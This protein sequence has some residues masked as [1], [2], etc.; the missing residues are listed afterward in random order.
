MKQWISLAAA[1]ATA[2][3][4]LAGCGGGDGNNDAGIRVIHAA[5][6][7]P[8]VNFLLNG[9]AVRFAL[10]YRQGTPLLLLTQ[11]SYDVAIEGLIPPENQTV[12]ELPGLS[13]SGDRD[14]TVVVTG[15]IADDSLD[16]LLFES[17]R[18]PAPDGKAR[19]QVLHAA[20]EA[21]PV[22][23]Y[24]TEPEAELAASV[25][26]GTL[27]Y[28]EDSG[29]L[30]VDAGL[31]RLRVTLAGDPDSLLFDS[32]N[33]SLAQNS[34]LFVVAVANT[35]AGPA[36]IALVINTGSAQADLLDRNTPG[37]LRVLHLSPDAPALDL[38]RQAT[39][40]E[41]VLPFLEGLMYPQSSGYQELAVAQYTV[42]AFD[43]TDA[44]PEA[45]P[46][47]SFVQTVQPGQFYSV[48]FTGLAEAILAQ[49]LI[50]ARRPVATEAKLRLVHASPEAGVVDIYLTPDGAELA[51]SLLILR[52]VNPRAETG[53]RPLPPGDYTLLV[54][55]PA[56]S[57]AEV[58]SSALNLAGGDVRTL[59][60]RDAPGGGEPVG[61]INIDDSAD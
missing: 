39:G 57:T 15:R 2:L 44:D 53:Y 42:R 37:A 23:L 28:L 59:I 31:G 19:L 17:S 21:P 50:D 11:G 32:P 13:F 55:E 8:R 30:D 9:Q 27:A 24:L 29:A 41:D 16:G 33:I 6:D 7:A 5:P 35:G 22:D 46:L 12:L 10:D 54:T 26:L 34:K 40:S 43:A 36:P 18:L 25:P 60:V 4:T 45:E 38:T 49:P 1:T 48:L 58:I 52:N 56:D 47:L 3:V 14:Y 61:L 20:P 51:E